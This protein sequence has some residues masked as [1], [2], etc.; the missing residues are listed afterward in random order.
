MIELGAQWVHGKDGNVVYPLGA[1]AGELLTDM[2]TL[3][4]TGYADNVVTGYRD[5]RKISPAQL[6][7]FK[8]VLESIY[9]ASKKELPRWNK[10]LGEY[11]QQK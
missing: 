10:S 11:F 8:A 2:H 3:E 4:S 5:G 9:D 6:A 7:E 1:A